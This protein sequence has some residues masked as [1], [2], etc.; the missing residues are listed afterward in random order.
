MRCAFERI[1]LHLMQNQFADA[2]ELNAMRRPDLAFIPD[3]SVIVADECTFLEIT[4]TTYIN[5]HRATL[6]QRE[7]GYAPA[8]NEQKPQNPRIWPENWHSTVLGPQLAP[9][10]I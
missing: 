5:A 1:S 6:M 3:Y 2:G 8:F 9:Q 7:I 4:T 10:L